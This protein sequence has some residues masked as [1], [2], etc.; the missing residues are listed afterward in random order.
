MNIDG[1]SVS[2]FLRLANNSDSLTGLIDSVATPS[3]KTIEYVKLM[4]QTRIRCECQGDCNTR[5]RS[6]GAGLFATGALSVP[7]TSTAICNT[8]NAKLLAGSFT[9]NQEHTVYLH[10]HSQ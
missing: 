7:Q 4:L 8:E 1:L 5:N 6:R 9:A 3:Y 2:I 10:N